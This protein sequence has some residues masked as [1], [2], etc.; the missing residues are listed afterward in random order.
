LAA[1]YLE[2]LR[3]DPIVAPRTKADAQEHIKILTWVFGRMRPKDIRPEHIGTYKRKRGAKARRRC[4]QELSRLRAIFAY[5]LETGW[6]TSDPTAGIKPWKEYARTRFID[7]VEYEAFKEFAHAHGEGSRVA[8]AAMEIAYLTTQRR[9]D[10]LA[11]KLEHLT[12]TGI[13]FEQ[14]KSRRFARDKHDDDA[15]TRVI[16]RWTPKLRQAL[17]DAKNVRSVTR[18]SPYLFCKRNGQPYTVNALKAFWQRLQ[19][20]W[21]KAGNRRF[22]FHDLRARGI[23]KLKEQGRKASEISGHKTESTAERIYDRRK[24][25]IGDAVE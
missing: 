17:A 21:E 11:I 12:E 14:A 22:H 16:V 24:Q 9:A 15:V 13:V 2:E 19:V 7:D 18:L 25:I 20:A 4:N 23:S 1:E 8:R 5:A 10:I 3:R 6:V